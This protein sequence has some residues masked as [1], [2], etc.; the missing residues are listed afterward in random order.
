MELC[1]IAKT[2][3][4]FS[5]LLFIERLDRWLCKFALWID[6]GSMEPKGLEGLFSSFLGFQFKCVILRFKFEITYYHDVQMSIEAII[7]ILLLMFF[8]SWRSGWMKVTS[9]TILLSII[10]KNLLILRE[11]RIF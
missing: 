11:D 6:L 9:N 8:N 2:A 3:T 4:F 5:S 7:D 1:I 10:G